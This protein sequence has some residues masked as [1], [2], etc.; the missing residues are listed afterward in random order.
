M[1]VVEEDADLE[2]LAAVE[3]IESEVEEYWE[4]EEDEA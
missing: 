3:E 4:E 2:R 1:V